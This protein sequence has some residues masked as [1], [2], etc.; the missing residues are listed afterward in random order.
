LQPIPGT[1]LR[2]KIRNFEVWGNPVQV[3]MDGLFPTLAFLLK[4][5]SGIGAASEPSNRGMMGFGLLEGNDPLS[6]NHHQELIAVLQLQS[7]AS[8]PWNDNLVLG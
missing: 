5:V 2:G 3:G 1:N 8:L 4:I 6:T 7:L